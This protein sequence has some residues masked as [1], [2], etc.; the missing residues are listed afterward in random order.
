MGIVSM[1]VPLW[2]FVEDWMMSYCIVIKCTYLPA[3]GACYLLASTK[4]LSLWKCALSSRM[5]HSVE[6][7][8][9]STHISCCPWQCLIL[10]VV[11][12]VGLPLRTTQ[13]RDML[14]LSA[15]CVPYTDLCE[16]SKTGPRCWSC[17]LTKWHM[18]T[19][20]EWLQSNASIDKCICPWASHYYCKTLEWWV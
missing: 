1:Q 10:V 6:D 16:L 8:A 18:K 19:W 2:M 4:L 5:E 13:Q 20:C 7:S 11:S 17:S 3:N 12:A 9:M 15:T 14:G